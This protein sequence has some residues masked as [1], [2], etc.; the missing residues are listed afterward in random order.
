MKLFDKKSLVRIKE[1]NLFLRYIWLE[2]LRLRSR[3]E[4]KLFSDCEC[5]NRLYFKYSGRYP[6]L[7][8]PVL[9]S[10]K[11]QWLKLH[12][13]NGLMP[14][15]GDK[16]EVRKYLK[17]RGFGYLLNQLIAV[18][19]T[20]DAFSPSNLPEK[21]VLK[22]THASGWNFIVKDKKKVKWWIRKKHMNY[23]LHN[24][25]EW[26]GR[27]WHYGEMKPRIICEKY[28]EDESGGLMDYKFFCFNGEPRFLQVNIDRG[29]STS[30]QNYY[31]LEWRLLPF[32]KSHPHN[33]N[34]IIPKPRR[35]DKMIEL[36]KDLSA[37]FPFV[38]VDLY[39][40]GGCIY[41]GEFT[42]FPCS[43]MPD[44][45]PSDYDRIVGEMLDLPEANKY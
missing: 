16:Y 22:A 1:S 9:F 37:P 4:R 6:N 39:Q 30:T 28:L 17:D 34:K 41:F 2:M 44:F 18:Y 38:R 36:A 24:D 12:Y 27:D 32:G 43:G 3:R 21:F 35:L 13:R 29:L 7:D 19:D 8:N 5:I 26:N 20:I 25:I 31:D 33:P 42:F 45:I 11:M 23:W 10:E 14:I 40:S 15:V